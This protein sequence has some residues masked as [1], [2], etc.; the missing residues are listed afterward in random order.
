MKDSSTDYASVAGDGTLPVVQGVTIPSTVEVIAPSAMNGGYQFS[1][2]VEGRHVL[3]AV[4]RTLLPVGG[5]KEGQQFHALVMNNDMDGTATTG[6]HNIPTG[7]WRDDLCDCL[8]NPTLCCF[9]WLCTPVILGQILTRNKMDWFGSPLEGRV[10]FLSAF[11][12]MLFIFVSYGL[13]DAVMGY[14][15]YPYTA[16]EYNEETGVYTLPDNIPSWVS[17]VDL[18]HQILTFP[19]AVAKGAK[20]V[21]A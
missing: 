11:K 18:I 4:V 17:I 9:T 19:K 16:V 20:I 2:D 1:V 8:N 3:V 15:T 6:G 14:I 13:A 12:V 10:T 5:V 7:R 21:A